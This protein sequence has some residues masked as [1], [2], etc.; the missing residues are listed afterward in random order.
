MTAIELLK[1]FYEYLF[2]VRQ[3]ILDSA[4]NLPLEVLQQETKTG[5]GSISKLLSHLIKTEDYWISQV[6]QGNPPIKFSINDSSTVVAIHEQWQKTEQKTREYLSS[7]SSERLNERH[8]VT[9]GDITHEFTV[10]QILLHL[11]THETHHRGQIIGLIRQ[12]GIDPPICDL[13]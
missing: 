6:L 5:W 13:L 1:E 2:D 7:L 8:S 12:F 4:A 3:R 11:A 10:Q 9:W